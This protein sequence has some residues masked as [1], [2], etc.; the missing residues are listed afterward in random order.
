MKKALPGRGPD[1]GTFLEVTL[2]S[3][4][5]NLAEKTYNGH[6]PVKAIIAFEHELFGIT[7]GVASLVLYIRD[8]QLCRYVVNREHSHIPDE[9]NGDHY[10]S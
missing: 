8:G 5:S 4:T 2:K 7:H 3:G 9:H 6:I 1:N 10:D